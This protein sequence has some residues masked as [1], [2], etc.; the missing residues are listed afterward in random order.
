MIKVNLLATNPAA[1]ARA[2]LPREQRNAF[3]GLG[4]LV[5]TALSVTGFWLYQ[6]SQ[7]QAVVTR[8]AAA[9]TELTRLKDAAKLVDQLATRK[10]E[11]AERLSLIDRLR[12][13]KRGPV[14]LLETVSRSV[15]D[16]LW[17]IEIK[18]VGGSVQVD[19]RAMSL[20]AVTDFTERLQN[21]GLFEHPVEILTT[22]TETVEET[23]V[24]RFSVKAE[25]VK[26][27]PAGPTAPPS[28][29]AA[30]AHGSPTIPGV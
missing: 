29:S 27:A 7:R 14:T 28:S 24:I 2:W 21:S 11:L 9:E 26:P 30:L 6:R 19:G 18:Q 5:V 10:S 15:P 13:S 16:G 22:A 1:P 3:V 25:A 23:T 12:S 17:L 20:T 8:I 4:L